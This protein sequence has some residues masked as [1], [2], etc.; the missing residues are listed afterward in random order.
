MRELKKRTVF[1]FNFKDM[2]KISVITS[3]YKG[4]EYIES[5]FCNFLQIDNI[6]E[7]EL[8]M[9]LNEPT[10]DEID[11]VTEYK[12]RIPY[13]IVIEVNRESL[14]ASW[15]RAIKLSHG[16]YLATWSIDD[17][18]TSE[19][20]SVQ[21]NTLDKNPTCMIATGN[22]YKI[23]KFGDIT[24]FLKKDSALKKDVNGYTQFRNG[25]FL[26]W[27][28]ELHDYIGY[29]DEQFNIGG[30]AEFYMRAMYNGHKIISTNSLLGYFLRESNKGLSKQKSKE[31][32]W[33]SQIIGMRYKKIFVCNIYNYYRTNKIKK[34]L[35]L[36]FGIYHN[37]KVRKNN[38]LSLLLS[39][40]LFW[41]PDLKRKSV[42]I[43]FC[44]RKYQHSVKQ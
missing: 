28:K 26:M 5:F 18:R 13:I 44:Y 14:Y 40:F 19:S 7:V 20:L 6:S 27:R 15:N 21:S 17:C 16:K 10:R 39:A 32:G 42:E 9:V 31:R 12:K 43:L 37:I 25:C 34:T 8:V 3:V 4:I 35:I 24:G 22:Y 23:F 36:N 38:L 29:F 1:I 30:D 41:L 33:E 2:I 11:I